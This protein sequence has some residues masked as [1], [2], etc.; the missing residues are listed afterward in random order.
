MRDSLEQY[1]EQSLSWIRQS[2]KATTFYEE[3]PTFMQKIEG[4]RNN[5]TL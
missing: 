3:A 5:F 2:S 1:E 4:K